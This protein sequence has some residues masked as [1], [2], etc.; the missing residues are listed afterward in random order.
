MPKSEISEFL[1]PIFQQKQNEPC[2]QE[3]ME[4][5]WDTK[6]VDHLVSGIMR[7]ELASNISIVNFCQIIVRYAQDLFMTKHWVDVRF[8]NIC[9]FENNRMDIYLQEQE[10]SKMTIDSDSEHKWKTILFN[11]IINDSLSQSNNSITVME[12]HFVTNNCDIYHFLRNAFEIGVIGLSTLNND[13]SKYNQL[14]ESFGKQFKY[15]NYSLYEL[16]RINDKLFKD[17]DTHF[18]QYDSGNNEVIR[19]YHTYHDYTRPN[20]GYCVG[21]H[22]LK[23]IYTI[24]TYVQRIGNQTLLFFGERGIIVVK[25]IELNLTR[26]NYMFGFSSP[27]CDCSGTDK[28]RKYSIKIDTWLA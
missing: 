2:D 22:H 18:L 27:I 15:S 4:E 12:I 3:R 25:P 21:I 26:Y 5:H 6:K 7:H 24:K 20:I 28:F 14:N 1:S 10:T 13:Y 23:S 16:S 9:Q 17:N 11:P 19:L 8:A